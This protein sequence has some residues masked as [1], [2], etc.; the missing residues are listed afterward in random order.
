[1]S[2]Q[3]KVPVLNKKQRVREKGA[4]LKKF[5]KGDDEQGNEIET[6]LKGRGQKTRRTGRKNIEWGG[7][8]FSIGAT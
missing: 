7:G 6:N 1:L 3:P 5:L 2:K 8:K 4:T